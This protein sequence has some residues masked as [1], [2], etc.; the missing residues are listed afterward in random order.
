MAV[1]LRS[2]IK[3]STAKRCGGW[4]SAP[5]AASGI[6]I[7]LLNVWND[8]PCEHGG[9]LLHYQNEM[10]PRPDPLAR[11]AATLSLQVFRGGLW[12]NIG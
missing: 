1:R 6:L 11:G 2:P 10:P 12:V 8:K 9:S 3:M 4:Q 5:N 7:E